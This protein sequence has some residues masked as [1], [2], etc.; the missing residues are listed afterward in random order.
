MHI[1]NIMPASGLAESG[2]SE[3]KDLYSQKQSSMTY[4]LANPYMIGSSILRFKRKIQKL[5]SE[6]SH[7][8]AMKRLRTE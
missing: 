8:R 7:E 6:Q 2:F 1:C 4:K 3:L 5:E